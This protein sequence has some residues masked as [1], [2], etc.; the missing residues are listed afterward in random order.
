MIAARM[1]SKSMTQI[2]PPFVVFDDKS[3]Y[4]DKAVKAFERANTNS[5]KGDF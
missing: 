2:L 1:G 4:R 3:V 5:I